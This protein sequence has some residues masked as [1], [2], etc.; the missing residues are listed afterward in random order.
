MTPRRA[1]SDGISCLLPFV[2]ERS[3]IFVDQKLFVLLFP[4]HLGLHL[5]HGA[6]RQWQQVSWPLPG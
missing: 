5:Q 3:V 1:G 4:G 6:V 2:G